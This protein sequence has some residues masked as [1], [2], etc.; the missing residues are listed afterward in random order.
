MTSPEYGSIV[1]SKLRHMGP[2]IKEQVTN[3]ESMIS[4]PTIL[5][6]LTRN[7]PPAG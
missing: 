3:D 7:D 6:I 1:I 5:Q 2:G 4:G